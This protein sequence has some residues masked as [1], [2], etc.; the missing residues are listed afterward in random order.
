[1]R[2]LESFLINLGL[3][4]DQKSFQSGQTA[5][6]GLTK[7]ALQLGAVFAGKFA[8]DKVVGQ[9]KDAGTNLDNFNKLTGVSTDSVQKLGYA[10]KMQ[11]G[12]ADDAFAALKNIQNLMASPLTGNTGWLADAAKFGFDPNVILNAKSTEDAVTGIA[13]QFEKLN[14]IQRVNVGHALGLTDAEVR[15]YSEGADALN[16]YRKEAEQIGI[17]SKPQTED[18][19]ALTQALKEMD[20][21][22]DS[23]GNRIGAQLTPALTEL[24]T[25]FNEFYKNNKELIDS[26]L[27]TFFGAVADNLKVISATLVVIG[28]ASGIKALAAIRVGLATLAG[29]GAAAGSAAGAAAATAGASAL[30]IAGGGLGALLYSGSLNSGEDEILRKRR[31]GENTD[32]RISPIVDF[33]QSKG[34]TREQAMGIAANLQRE[35]NFDP[36]AVGDGGQARG[37]AQWHPDRQR[38]FEKFAGKNI[39]QSTLE[40]QLNFVDYE[41]TKG[42][43]KGAGDRLRQAQTPYEAGSIVSKYYE[44]PKD[45]DGEADM[46]GTL[47]LSYPDTLYEKDPGKNKQKAQDVEKYYQAPPPA[48]VSIDESSIKDLSGAGAGNAPVQDNRTYTF[49]GADEGVIRRVLR[50]E[51]GDMASQAT[52]EF[53][54]AEQ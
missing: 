18:A 17:I 52:Q 15:V 22:T 41:L 54:G 49:N 21:V 19:K 4:V 30:A 37:V 10:L 16:R 13:E 28:G 12:N 3:K 7:S 51:V 42:N 36:E 2:V 53:Q 6:D 24:V 8:L 31:Q 25:E 26:G 14:T 5:F 47:A 29:G 9:F 50:E 48:P 38:E 27:D 35:S 34:W 43:E 20:T 39:R 45:R 11:G 40:D 44:R 1:M 23:L 46:R 33:F 32:D